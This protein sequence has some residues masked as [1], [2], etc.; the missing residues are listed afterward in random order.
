MRISLIGKDEERFVDPCISDFHDEPWVDEI[1]VIDGGSTDN[2]LKELKKYPKVKVFVHP[3][4]V[5]YHDAQIMQRN[6]QLTYHRIGEIFFILDFDEK[7]SRELKEYLE[8]ISET[9]HMHHDLVCVSR[10]SYESLRVPGTTEA[11]VDEKGWPVLAQTIG[12]YPDYQP[13]LIK[14]KPGMT[15]INSPHHRLVA[16]DL[17]QT[18]VSNAD[19]IHYHG[20]FDSKDRD[21]IEKLWAQTQARRKHLGLV[22]DVFDASLPPELVEYSEPEAWLQEWEKEGKI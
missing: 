15:W 11:I 6:I 9:S 18:N 17:K 22:C 16:P 5:W 7:M 1:I 8:I 12:Q 19:I 2:T 14:R 13:R 4:P 3:Y 21:N 20:K 10:K